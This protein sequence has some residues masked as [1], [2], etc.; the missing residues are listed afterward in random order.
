MLSALIATDPE[1]PLNRELILRHLDAGH[2]PERNVRFWTLA[3]LLQHQASYLDAASQGCRS[4]PDPEVKWLAEII[5]RPNDPELVATVREM[6]LSDQFEA[7]AWPVLRLLRV[8]PIEDLVEDLCE[9]LERSAGDTP[10][11][12]DALYALASPSV[13]PAAVSTLR[14]MYGIGPVV[15]KTIAVAR[16]SDRGSIRN[17]A[18]LLAGFE[19]PS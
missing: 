5:Q 12:Y 9:A 10:L 1:A 3:G 14:S 7:K 13:V 16:N 2:E 4:D 17:F 19:H 6:L 11:A 18:R 15:E 8:R